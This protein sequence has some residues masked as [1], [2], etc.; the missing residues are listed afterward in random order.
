M[1]EHRLG[2]YQAFSWITIVRFL[3]LGLTLGYILYILNIQ[4]SLVSAKGL[5]TCFG[6]SVVNNETEVGTPFGGIQ[7]KFISACTC[8]QHFGK[9]D[10]G[11][12]HPYMNQ[13]RMGCSSRGNICKH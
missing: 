2:Y 10:S 12:P 11:A 4:N 8:K 3:T 13:G 7:S 6:L 9:M 5:K 1:F